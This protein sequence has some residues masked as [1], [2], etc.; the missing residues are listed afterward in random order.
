VAVQYLANGY[1]FYV[2]GRIPDGKDPDRVDRKLIEQ[3]D[4]G[5][6]KWTRARRRAVGIAAIQYIR[7]DRFFVLLATHGRHP[8]FAA[9]QS[10]LR[11]AR[12]VPIR[13]GGYSMS[14]RGGHPHVRIENSQY[15]LL[16]ECTVRLA[17]EGDL[18]RLFSFFYSLPFEPYA[19]IRR[20]LLN[21]VR[22]ASR[23][24]KGG[25]GPS[26]PYRAVRLRR[27]V[28]HVYETAEEEASTAPD[29]Y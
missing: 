6:S 11:D 10:Q 19:P 26:V 5:V 14:Y 24:S 28:V 29:S 7:H 3:Y 15:R 20:Q 12:R 9:E 1:W 25:G 8:F 21:L 2:T 23:V 22:A 16:K 17:K 4:I 27:R 13:Y 18:G